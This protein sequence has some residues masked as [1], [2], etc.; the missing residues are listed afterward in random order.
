ME[1]RDYYDNVALRIVGNKCYDINGTWVYV[2]NGNYICNSAGNWVLVIDGDRVYDTQDNWVYNVREDQI[3][4]HDIPAFM[5]AD[6]TPCSYCGQDLTYVKDGVCT[7]CGTRNSTAAG[8]VP[9]VSSIPPVVSVYPEPSIPP[10][11]SAHPVPSIPPVAS[12]SPA[13]SIPPA[14]SISHASHIPP[15]TSARQGPPITSLPHTSAIP[16]RPRASSG[17]QARV[18]PKPKKSQ[19]P[20]LIASIAV[21]LVVGL[22]ILFVNS[23]SGNGDAVGGMVADGGYYVP[24]EDGGLA[25]DGDTTTS[26][27]YGTPTEN[28]SA[29]G[30]GENDINPG[31][32]VSGDEGSS[33][34]D[35]EAGGNIGLPGTWPVIDDVERVHISVSDENQLR[36]AVGQAGETPTEITLTTD[37]ELIS[38]LIILDGSNIKLRSAD[39]NRFSLVT[40]RDMTAL[41]V[42][43][44]A[45][46]VIENV[47]IIRTEG[48]SGTGIINQGIVN[49]H[50]SDVIGHT[51][52]G[53]LNYGPFLMTDSVINNNSTGGDGGGG[54]L[55]HSV[56]VMYNSTINHNTA[57]AG[58]G[59]GVINHS[60]FIMNG[61]TISYN[62]AGHDGGGGGVLNYY[63][64]VMTDSTISDNATGHG[65]GG[66][67]LNRSYFV[68]NNS[69]ISN[70]STFGRGG[71][72]RSDSSFTMHK[73][74]ISNNS[75]NS[76][77]GG[78]SSSG[79]FV[80]TDGDIIGNTTQSSGGGVNNA[81]YF[82]MYSGNINNN[83]AGVYVEAMHFIF[84]AEYNVYRGFSAYRFS[85]FGGGG[86]CNSSNFIMH[87]GIISGNTGTSAVTNN[88]HF[89]MYDGIIKN[90]DGGGVISGW[91]NDNNSIFTMYGGVIS[92]NRRLG[93]YYHN[94]RGFNLSLNGRFRGDLGP[95]EGVLTFHYEPASGVDII[96]GGVFNMHGGT[97]YGHRGYGISSSGASVID[98]GTIQNNTECG[99]RISGYLSITNGVIQNNGG[100]GVRQEGGNF[101]ITG[102]TINNNT[103]YGIHHTA[104]DL[105]ING[106]WIFDN[107]TDITVGAA[108]TFNNNVFDPNIGAIGS[109]PPP[110]AVTNP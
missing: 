82:T 73:G 45:S 74:T 72:I 20:I 76:G 86:V 94:D 6:T 48:T 38:D 103:A 23:R 11:S 105:T 46:L 52:S 22:V 15:V 54:V 67:V 97:I 49:M 36:V 21:V 80:M 106:G 30:N 64:L 107:G 31:S 35:G 18:A 34:S 104:G 58:S 110:G 17:A 12:V 100:S 71:G 88:L 68:M 5:P 1:F 4:R 26:G 108:G 78:V 89:V 57:N 9:A 63:Q 98:S 55:N 62:T 79:Y 70:N 39:G 50:G 25:Y 87:Q 40:T 66:G 44:D 109:A 99:V 7:R 24:A 91:H 59:G 28:G 61:S 92:N 2:K 102:G 65:G 101:T 69:I 8:A 33:V 93:G 85:R 83:T 90:T 16:Q 19:L 37:I 27:Y 81:G 29:Y 41:T 75:A 13:S 56:F 60:Q 96:G 10:V 32:I 95:W 77:G 3:H 47:R 14:S 53:V 84:D 43:W 51:T 42:G